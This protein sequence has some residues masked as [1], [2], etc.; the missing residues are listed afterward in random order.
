MA[1]KRAEAE[2]GERR[3]G[4]AYSASSVHDRSSA[5]PSVGV[6]ALSSSEFMNPHVVARQ[7]AGWRGMARQLSL[8]S[9]GERKRS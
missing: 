6:S 8:E 3:R 1:F 7:G 4:A 2:G 9:N 5:S